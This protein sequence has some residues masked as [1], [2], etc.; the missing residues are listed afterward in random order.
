[1]K[2]KFSYIELIL[3]IFL[4]LQNS[5]TA[6]SIELKINRFIG[7][8]FLLSLS[9][10]KT[11]LVDS[12]SWNN[13]KYFFP[14]R[15]LAKGIYRLSFDKS[16]WLNFVYDNE[17]VSIM[18]T[19]NS[20]IDSLKIVKSESNK[21]FYNFLKLNKTYKTKTELLRF[22]LANYPKD[23]KFCT[24]TQ[25]R[26]NE[27]QN[28]Y[29]EFVNVTSQNK[30]NSF[31]AKY[32]RSSQLPILDL[33]IPLDKQ[34]AYL[35]S[36]ALNNVNFNDASLINSDVFTNKTIEYLTY[37]RNP[38]LPK[39]LVEKEF[40]SAADSIL[41]KA[42]VNQLVYQQIAEYLI[43]GFKQFSFDE[44]LD[45]V[46]KNYVLK[47]D[48]CLD[49]KTEGMIKRRIEQ[50]KRFKVGNVVPNILLQETNGKQIEL[51]KIN[52]EKIL[53]LFYAS[54]CPHCQELLPKLNELKKKQANDKFEIFAISLD[55]KK[56]DWIVFAKNNC[57]SFINVSDL[58]GWDGKAVNDYF[59][60][61]TPTM[62]LVD[63]QLR[64]ISIP[65]RLTDLEL[66]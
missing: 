48:L 18:T 57:D 24:E 62:F 9:G 40:M 2:R 1:M 16:K 14:N 45:Y 7:K 65:A 38:Q 22:I 59:V 13:G 26:L 66:K 51:N 63:K 64:I 37:F 28:E 27:L 21:L 32:V 12:A 15:N 43:E 30:P 10:E 44:A 47:D 17:D 36:N 41:N 60:Y 29:V 35:K 46:L 20:V 5:I 31:I 23:D 49:T 50:A 34:L 19:A 3:I 42:R 56:E 39:E 33:S 11:S 54:W 53:I 52:S 61:A 25:V 4:I 58:K 8:V 55:T 6:Q